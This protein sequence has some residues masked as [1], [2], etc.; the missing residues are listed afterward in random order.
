MRLTRNTLELTRRAWSCA[1]TPVTKLVLLAYCLHASDQG[2]CWPSLARIAT[3]TGLNQRT[4]QRH[5]RILEAAG[6]LVALSKPRAATQTYQLNMQALGLAQALPDF[7]SATTPAPDAPTASDLPGLPELGDWPELDFTSGPV[8]NF[9]S[10]GGALSPHPRQRVHKGAAQS[11]QTPGTAP[12]KL[13]E[14]N[15][16]DEGTEH[17]AHAP[18]LPAFTAPPSPQAMPTASPAS[19]S[20]AT[21]PVLVDQEKTEAQALARFAAL[22]QRKG[23]GP[24]TDATLDTLKAEGELAGLTLPQVVTHCVERRWGTFRAAW[25]TPKPTHRHGSTLAPHSAHPVPAM[26]GDGGWG[27]ARDA[28][29]SGSTPQRLSP[30]GELAARKLAAF[31]ASRNAPP[32]TPEQAA[33]HRAKLAALRASYVAG[34]A[35]PA[36][37]THAQPA[38]A[39]RAVALH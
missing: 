27:L 29:A 23:Y 9:T 26:L 38:S 7:T 15:R 37:A 31:E 4:V 25:L 22:H 20:S 30:D 10:G 2:L 12:P 36:R 8:D 5:V 13:Y 17:A 19:R 28:R 24:V 14:L 33:T 18:E 1:L 6:A 16:T 39:A 32:A 21:P 3:F 11:T 35:S 34:G